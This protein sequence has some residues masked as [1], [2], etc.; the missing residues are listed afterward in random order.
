MIPKQYPIKAS[1]D[2]NQMYETGYIAIE[3]SVNTEGNTENIE[4]IESQPKQLID[5]IAISAIRNTIYR[6]VYI[7][8][9]PQEK[10]N[11]LIRHEFSYPIKNEENLEPKEKD[12][13]LN[14]P[15]A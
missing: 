3:Y 13:P 12:K 8:G 5:K 7:E 10:P 11:M 4:I 6:P 15:I 14:N 1:D 9:I 2:D